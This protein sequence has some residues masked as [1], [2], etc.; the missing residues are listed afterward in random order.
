MLPLLF[1]A[2]G[3]L[4]LPTPTVSSA[5]DATHA[6]ARFRT[7][8]VL[9]LS[10][11]GG[12]AG[13][14]GYPNDATK[15]GIPTYYAATGAMAGTSA[16]V[17]VMGALSDYLNFGFWFSHATFQNA[18]W[19]SAGNAG[20]LRVDA[21]PL[22]GLDSPLYSR[23]SGLGL[24]GQ[25][26]IGGGHFVSTVP[27]GPASSGTQSFVAVGALYEWSFGKVLGGHFA[28]GPSLEYD[29]IFSQPF[30]RHGLLAS[31]RLVFYGGP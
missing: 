3:A 7:G 30:E 24:F 26:G 22:V 9:G 12:I 20:G 2:A 14:S 31:A 17:L 10:A 8:L 5:P 13:A 29:A 27:N 23:L 11:G 25:F 21:F 4:S 28:V 19:H 18:D 16:T 15:I 6:P 1:A